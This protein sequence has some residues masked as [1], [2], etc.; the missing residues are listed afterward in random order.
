MRSPGATVTSRAVV[1]AVKNTLLYFER[2]RDELYARPPPRPP[3][4]TTM[5]FDNLA[6]NHAPL[7]R[8]NMALAQLLGLCPLL[9]VTTTVVNGLALGLATR[10][11]SSSRT[12]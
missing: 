4:P 9:A 8:N 6:R 3:T 5:N 7:W 10:P 12:P 1:G 2:H 11:S